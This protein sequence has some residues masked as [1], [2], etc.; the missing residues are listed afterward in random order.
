MFIIACV[1]FHTD[2]LSDKVIYNTYLQTV[3]NQSDFQSHNFLLI[4]YIYVHIHVFDD[5]HLHKGHH[6]KSITGG[7]KKGP[8]HSHN[9]AARR[10]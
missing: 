4:L 3:L 8:I 1:T 5:M 10:A 6:R 9:I 2:N 7:I